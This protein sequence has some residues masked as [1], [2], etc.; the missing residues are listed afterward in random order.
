[1]SPTLNLP[2]YNGSVVNVSIIHGGCLQGSTTFFTQTP[3]VGHDA[4]VDIPSH[5]FLVEND[6]TGKKVLF[7]LGLIKAW[8]EKHSPIGKYHLHNPF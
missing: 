2:P 4:W 8:R 1:M 5:S 6:R 3:V 7:D